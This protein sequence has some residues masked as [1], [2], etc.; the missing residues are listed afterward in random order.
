MIFADTS[1]YHFKLFETFFEIAGKVSEELY[2]D[3]AA[4]R[5]IDVIAYDTH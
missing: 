4:S 2:E 5:S 1:F 3:T